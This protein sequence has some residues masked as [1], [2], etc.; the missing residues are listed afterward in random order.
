MTRLDALFV[1]NNILN[2]KIE[3][4]RQFVQ[5]LKRCEEQELALFKES[6]SFIAHGV[7]SL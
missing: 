5:F 6:D 4:C 2:T 3:M 7:V 1:P